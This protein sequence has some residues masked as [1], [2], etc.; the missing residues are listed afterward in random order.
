MIAVELADAD[1]IRQD[2]VHVTDGDPVVV[3]RSE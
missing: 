2:I 1:S 3:T